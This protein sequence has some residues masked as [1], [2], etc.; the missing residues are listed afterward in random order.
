MKLLAALLFAFPPQP[1]GPEPAPES[2]P[3]PT[4]RTEK[5]RPGGWLEKFPGPQEGFLIR[6]QS[7][8]T[9]DRYAGR[10]VSNDPQDAAMRAEPLTIGPAACETEDGRLRA[11]A[12]PFAVGDDRT[13][14]WHLTRTGTGLRLRHEHRG[15]PGQGSPV[16][17]YGGAADGGG[18]FTRQAFPADA[19]TRAL[20]AEAGR[21]ASRENVW[22]LEIVPGDVLAYALDR[23]DRAFRAEFDLTRPVADDVQAARESE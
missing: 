19:E 16:T 7:L 6:L 12:I 22:T 21:E 9:G 8:C 20:F 14:T 1:G 23:P 3:E 2:K 10:V 17:G 4:E 15:V 13:R 11:I 5:T 18:T